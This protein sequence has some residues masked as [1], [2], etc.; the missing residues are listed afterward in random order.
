[1]PN[2]TVEIVTRHTPS[3]LV[4]APRFDVAAPFIGGVSAAT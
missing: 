2:S 3:R 1:M 4:F